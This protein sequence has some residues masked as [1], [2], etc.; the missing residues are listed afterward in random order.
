MLKPENARRFK[1]EGQPVSEW[2]KWLVGRNYA[3]DGKKVVLH[4]LIEGTL[5]A[6]LGDTIVISTE[7]VVSIE[8]ST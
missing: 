2:P 5:T 6:E 7:Q 4:F 1:W 3:T 8:R